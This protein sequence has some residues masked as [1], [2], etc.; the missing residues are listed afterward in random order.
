MAT[1]FQINFAPLALKSL[2]DG[3]DKNQRCSEGLQ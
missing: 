2:P 1:A 3:V